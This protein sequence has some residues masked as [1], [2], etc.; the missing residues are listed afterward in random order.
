[1]TDPQI[2][3]AATF[4]FLT[5]VGETLTS[6]QP[7][8]SEYEAE[9]L[10]EGMKALDLAPDWQLAWG[11]LAYRFPP[12]RQYDN[13]MFVA[14]RDGE[15][16]VAV[17]GTNS[18]APLD[19]L[20]ED[21]WVV[22][23]EPWSKVVRVKRPAGLHPAIS[24]GTNLGL[25]RLLRTPIQGRVPGSGTHLVDFFAGQLAGRSS[26][27]VTVTGHS[28]GGALAPA[29]ALYL[30]DTRGRE[31]GW[32]PRG[33]TQ[34]ASVA[35]AGPTPGNADFAT[36]LDQRIGAV[37]R[38]VVN[39]LD[40]VPMAWNVDTL[41]AVKHVYDDIDHPVAP[42]L[43]ERGAI[44]ALVGLIKVAGLHFAQYHA[45]G[46]GL[47][48]L[49]E[50]KDHGAPNFLAQALWQHVDGYENQLGIS[51]L[52]QRLVEIFDDWCR[53]QPPCVCPGK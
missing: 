36:Y 19:W 38:R 47:V 3:L 2:Q 43:P 33:V 25:Q 51:G 42:D 49:D 23:E 44:D 28:L 4:A 31:G 1:M 18:T 46:A 50:L 34:L 22:P 40:L 17:R 45:S 41:E 39:P 5:Y 37:A 12:S 13:F 27:T 24:A 35:F 32:D 26:A 15:Y 10:G 6:C 16:V 11:P 14:R 9:L 48:T 29:L 8:I 53:H 7:E 52:R 21:F 20:F 30:A